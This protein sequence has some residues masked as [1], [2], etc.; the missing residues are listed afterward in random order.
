LESEKEPSS[1]RQKPVSLSGLLGTLV[2]SFGDFLSQLDAPIKETVDGV[3]PQDNTAN[4]G[5]G[6][7]STPQQPVRV[8]VESLPPRSTPDQQD[9]GR[10][11]WKRRREWGELI[12]SILTLMALVVY[13]VVTWK[14]WRT[15]NATY[16]EIQRQTASSENAVTEAR[17]A[18]TQS[19][20]QF[21]TD[22]RPY[23]WLTGKKPPTF[24][25]VTEFYHLKDGPVYWTVFYSNYGKSPAIE[26]CREIHLVHA[27]DT[28][29]KIYDIPH[30]TCKKKE[31]GAILVPTGIFFSTAKTE[32]SITDQ[33]YSEIT[34]GEE[35]FAV[36]GRFDYRD[37]AGGTYY[38]QFCLL[39][40]KGGAV[41]NCYNHNHVK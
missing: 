33:N 24:A 12:V 9:E 4:A 32:D 28:F 10:K 23:V 18:I 8:V 29:N 6:R 14:Q 1:S 26:V 17:N 41:G 30:N 13:T 7:E 37:A 38:S 21:Q 27:P 19:K 16:C 11:R 39:I 34:S 36:F 22:Q 3:H 15:M 40:L 2:S 5:Q 25:D 20:N 31:E 35:S